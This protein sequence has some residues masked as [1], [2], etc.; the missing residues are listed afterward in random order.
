M[1]SDGTIIVFTSAGDNLVAND[2]NGVH[3]VFV[4]DTVSGS[5]VR[6]SVDSSGLEADQMSFGAVI[7]ADGNVVAFESSATN[8]VSGDTNGVVDIFVHDR[9]S[10]VTD[11][12]SIDS[13]GTEADAESS[14]PSISAD[15]RFVAFASTAT[16][17]VS[18]DNNN[19][20]DIFV[21]DRLLATTDRVSVNPTGKGGDDVSD[22]PS[23]SGDGLRVAFQSAATNLVTGDT[24]AVVDVFVRDR[25]SNTTSR[26]SVDSAGAQASGRSEFPEMSPRGGLVMFSSHASDLVSGDANARSDVFIRDIANGTTVRISVDSSGGEGDGA[27]GESGAISEDEHVFAFDSL[28]TNL[29]HADTNGWCDVFVHEKCSAVAFWSNYGA[30]LGGTLGVPA[31]TSRQNPL[32]GTT[33]T[34]DVGNSFGMPTIGLLVV[35]V[36][37]GSFHTRFGADLLVV[38]LVLLPISFSFGSDSFT[39]A[40]PTDPAYC[41]T[42]VFLQA[43]EVDPGA[44]KGVSFTEGLEL[45]LGIH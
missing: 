21:R 22:S 19:K 17:L 2:L 24:N 10:G 32:L 25:V 23:I 39:G 11:R 7:S 30:G 38:P 26:C 18:G 27:S 4:R 9:V 35:G 1:S 16:N 36:Q 20:R 44:P 8:L 13:A 33:I 31:I 28:A 6:V 42:S 29:V 3:D 15:G 41:G 43:V 5:T 37:Q 12:V 40:L 45:D 14:R 34:V